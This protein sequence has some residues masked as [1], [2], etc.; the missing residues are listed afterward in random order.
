MHETNIEQTNIINEDKVVLAFEGKLFIVNNNLEVQNFEEF[1]TPISEL[2]EM[3]PFSLWFMPE[4]YFLSTK[5]YSII[6]IINNN[7]NKNIFDI[8]INLIVFIDYTLICLKDKEQ[9]WNATIT[10]VY[11]LGKSEENNNIINKKIEIDELMLIYENNE[12]L[13][14]NIKNIV[15]SK[16][17]DILSI[18]GYDKV[19]K[20]YVKIYDF[21]TFNHLVQN[22]TLNNIEEKNNIISGS[23]VGK[24]KQSDY[25]LIYILFMLILIIIGFLSLNFYEYIINFIYLIF[26]NQIHLSKNPFVN[27]MTMNKKEDINISNK[28]ESDKMIFQNIRNIFM[29][30]NN[31]EINDN[32]NDLIERKKTIDLDKSNNNLEIIGKS[33]ENDNKNILKS[34]RKDLNITKSKKSLS[35][36]N[37]KR[38]KKIKKSL[39]ITTFSNSNTE[40]VEV[41]KINEK[42]PYSAEKKY[43]KDLLNIKK[44]MSS[45]SSSLTRLEKDFKDITL[46]KKSNIGII[47]KARH[48]IDEETY[49]IKIMR[50]SNPND[51]Q[52]VISEAKNMTKIHTKHIIEYITCWFDKS[53]GKYEYFFGE[54]NDNE[55]CSQSIEN[56]EKNF[57]I[58]PGNIFAGYTGN[59]IENGKITE[60]GSKILDTTNGKFIAYGVGFLSLTDFSSCN[61]E[62]RD[63]IKASSNG[64]SSDYM[65]KLFDNEM[66]KAT[67]FKKSNDI[68]SF[69]SDK[70]YQLL[71]EYIAK[72]GVASHIVNK[73]E[74]IDVCAPIE[75]S[76]AL[77]YSPNV[78]S[79]NFDANTQ[80]YHL[81]EGDEQI[82]TYL[83]SNEASTYDRGI[84]YLYKN[85]KRKSLTN[86]S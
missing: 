17:N 25:N 69:D 28:N 78:L 38:F 11:F 43:D 15:G 65:Q 58:I 21:N 54:E 29:G 75:C 19:K 73:E 56:E 40:L 18:H 35:D 5:K 27:E 8:D 49:A 6:K 12:I 20:K 66:V 45:P 67:C 1:T 70:C 23:Y 9:V 30:N 36:K 42:N 46:I 72:V 39:N 7:P 2:V 24:S 74:Q 37:I 53:L 47:L 71:P 77:L 60:D 80:A 41:S 32:N 3:T 85:V 31:S 86:F 83:E 63:I 34:L 16:Y 52:S 55:S 61:K 22:N 13:E 59:K 51:E 62:A 48:K 64:T 14:K 82:A 10:N 33:P 44:E 81:D 57:D 4:Y 26:G 50:L 76:D 84:Y 68:N 79:S